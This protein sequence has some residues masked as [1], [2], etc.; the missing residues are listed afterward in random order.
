MMT[1][2]MSFSES[3][4]KL[5]TDAGWY[6]G[7][8]RDTNVDEKHLLAWGYKIFPTVMEFLS[9]FGN[10][11]ILLDD[12]SLELAILDVP[13]EELR[14]LSIV[15]AVKTSLCIVGSIIGTGV[16]TQIFI[17]EEGKFYTLSGHTVLSLIGSS[18]VEAIENLVSGIP[19]YTV[20]FPQHD[21]EVRNILKD[22]K[23]IILVGDPTIKKLSEINE[24][25]SNANYQVL[26]VH[27]E[28]EYENNQTLPASNESADIV[29]L[30]DW[31]DFYPNIVEYAM[32][33]GAKALWVEQVSDR[34]L[35]MRKTDNMKMY[36][37]YIVGQHKRLLMS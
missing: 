22:S 15:D 30:M 5:L 23:K 13:F 9:E 4:H 36:W 32:S 35:E 10:L 20:L 3:T 7:R 14:Q 16:P 26:E 19:K 27:T 33:A 37:G 24:Y 2:T 12:S 34:L 31:I 8:T 29:Y 28:S 6:S 17:D 18:T 25:L 1:A 21:D 11:R